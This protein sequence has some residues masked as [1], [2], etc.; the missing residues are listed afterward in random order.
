ML[1]LIFSNL[2]A[3]F[4]FIF[5]KLKNFFFK[6]EIKNIKIFLYMII[7]FVLALKNKTF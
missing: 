3:F 2:I 7:K 6:K 4:I 5:Y 1:S